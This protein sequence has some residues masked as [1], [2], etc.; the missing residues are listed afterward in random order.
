[1]TG[2]KCKSCGKGH[3]DVRRMVFLGADLHLC[4][5]CINLCAEIIGEMDDGLA[6]VPVRELE[7]LRIK[8]HQATVAQIWTKSVR[9]AIDRADSAL[10]ATNTQEGGVA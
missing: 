9:E 6:T 8:A 4:N 7:A 1:M 3:L 2:P 5:E 10:Q